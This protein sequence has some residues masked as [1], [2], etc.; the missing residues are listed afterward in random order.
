MDTFINTSCRR[1][2][3]LTINIPELKWK[4]LTSISEFQGQ[5]SQKQSLIIKAVLRKSLEKSK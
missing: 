4:N 5:P 1:H 3:C 2:L